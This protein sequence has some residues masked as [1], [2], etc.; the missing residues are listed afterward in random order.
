MKN[1]NKI[2][3]GLNKLINSKGDNHSSKQF[4]VFVGNPDVRNNYLDQFYAAQLTEIA[5][6][7]RSNS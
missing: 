7:V 5:C 2:S 6:T 3:Q 1:S 4:D